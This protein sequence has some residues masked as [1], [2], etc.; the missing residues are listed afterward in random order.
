MPRLIDADVVSKAARPM[1]IEKGR[2]ATAVKAVPLLYIQSAD[3]IEAEPV[4]KWISVND[5]LPGPGEDGT[6]ECVLVTDGDYIWMAYWA[7]KRWYFAECTNALGFIEWTEIT[8]WMPLP[9]LPDAPRKRR[10]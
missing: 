5:R 10:R 2:N 4:Q 7:C 8:H 9:E 3:T 1:Y 6:P